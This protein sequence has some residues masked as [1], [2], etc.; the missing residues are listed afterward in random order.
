MDME[1]QPTDGVFEELFP[2]G[3][4][5]SAF[6]NLRD[7]D[8]VSA[9]HAELTQAENDLLAALRFEKRRRDWLGGRLAAKRAVLRLAA[10]SGAC[11][12]CPKSP[13]AVEILPGPTREPHVQAPGS[14]DPSQL[15]VS[16]SH[17]GQLAGAVACCREDGRIGFDMECV[18]PVE[19]AL[20]S[21]AFL[22]TEIQAI[23]SVP[24]PVRTS[25]IHAFWTA[26]EAVSKALGTGL[27][28]SLH[29]IALSLPVGARPTETIPD[30]LLA[31]VRAGSRVDHALFTVH[32]HQ[33]GGYVLS[34]AAPSQPGD[35]ARRGEARRREA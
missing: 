14:R 23:D 26:K 19:P 13:R 31:R 30:C 20:Y 11:G 27:T 29:D 10:G 35:Q 7:L 34:L 25:W 33:I 8:P 18:E 2:G 9:G 6:V 5:R 32:T 22:P 16:I 12:W 3:R 4:L 15:Q 21:L 24:V 28:T 1:E 17:S